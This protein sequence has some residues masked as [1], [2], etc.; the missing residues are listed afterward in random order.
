MLTRRS[1]QQKVN[2]LLSSASVLEQVIS[3]SRKRY[4]DKQINHSRVSGANLLCGANK[5]RAVV[6]NH[7]QRRE[8]EN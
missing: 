6:I 4:S 3:S 7:R 5:E 1:L 2:I 8:R